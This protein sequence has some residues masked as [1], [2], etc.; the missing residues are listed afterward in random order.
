MKINRR[1]IDMRNKITTKSKVEVEMC[2]WIFVWNIKMHTNNT[3]YFN[4]KNNNNITIETYQVDHL[5]EN[6]MN[7]NK[8]Q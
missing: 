2:M 5:K 3:M 7:I 4:K 1:S 6:K 8:I